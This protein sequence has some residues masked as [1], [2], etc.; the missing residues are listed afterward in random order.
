MGKGDGTKGN[1]ADAVEGMNHETVDAVAR[2]IQSV[3]SNIIQLTVNRR[4]IT[5]LMEIQ[6]NSMLV[7]LVTE[8]IDILRENDN[9]VNTD[10]SRPI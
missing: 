1:R 2:L 5:P 6:V 7:D 8:A 4:T 3:G 10:N 9:A